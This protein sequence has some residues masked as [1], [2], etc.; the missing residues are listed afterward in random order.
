MIKSQQKNKEMMKKFVNWVMNFTWWFL[1]ELVDPEA[2]ASLLRERERPR[3][4][5]K[6]TTTMARLIWTS[7]KHRSTTPLLLL[8]E[9]FF[10][11]ICL[12]R[13][14]TPYIGWFVAALAQRSPMPVSLSWP[15]DG[16][17]WCSMVMLMMVWWPISLCFC[18]L[19]ILCNKQSNVVCKQMFYNF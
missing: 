7:T 17:G 19:I 16:R 1:Q 15:H 3:L 18:F 11:M 13:N 12:W 8:T 14:W 9:V 4:E 6:H 5:I 2:C 10:G